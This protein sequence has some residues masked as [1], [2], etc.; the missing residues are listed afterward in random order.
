MR[1]KNL[2]NNKIAIFV[3][4]IK[5]EKKNNFQLNHIICPK[6][7]DFK[8]LALI[9]I[10]NEIIIKNCINK[11]KTIFYSLKDF[12]NS[13]Q[14][15]IKCKKCQMNIN[16]LNN[17]LYFNS[18]KEYICSLCKCNYKDSFKYIDNFYKCNKHNKAFISYCKE[19][20]FNLCNDCEIMHK[21]H[22][23]IYFKQLNI[24]EKK[25]N[26]IKENIEEFQNY[27]KEYKI[28]IKYLDL[29]FKDVFKEVL[30]NIKKEEI[31][32]EY[33]I[34][35][36]YNLKNYESLKNISNIDIKNFIKDIK[37]FLNEENIIEKMKYLYYKYEKIPKN[38]VIIKY[39]NDRTKIKIFGEEF[40][41]NNN[42]NC[43]MIFE[44]KKYKIQSFF[45]IK[46][47]NKI[48]E[49]K[50]IETKIIN[51]M[52]YM[53]SRCN[54][55]LSSS[56]ISKWD[57]SNV[58]NM[59]HI[60]GGCAELQFIPDISKWDTSNVTNMSEMFEYC[61][62]LQSLPDI[63]K[64]NTSNVT[65][66]NNLFR[67]CINLSSLPDISKWNTGN[68]TNM[69]C[70]FDDCRSLLT[71]PD[72]SNWDTS[73]V[74]NMSHMFAECNKLKSLPDISN[75]NTSNVTQMFRMF[76][77]CESLT[78]LPDISKWNILKADMYQMFVN[79]KKSLNIPKNWNIKNSI[80]D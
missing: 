30:N 15:D 27:I 4:K 23:I 5:S 25:R 51:D 61:C 53:F 17:D 60:F 45:P 20:N 16:N 1:I 79:C 72:I 22:E 11:H 13:Q 66:M 58:T 46:T 68:V 74:M 37:L 12:I 44:D 48:I 70:M 57:T 80:S 36:L 18:D 67:G 43:Y 76:Y 26:Q 54:S 56:D 7:Q 42:N 14:I 29:L 32:F 10:E 6:C 40:V 24:N 39:N 73:N 34:Y 52:S 3:S 33:I 63:S 49:I 55:L 19:C 2:V 28:Q 38:E 62:P 69:W 65:D 71:L 21:K 75:W 50:L 8:N 9:N 77:Y 78:S 47:K 31:L 41:K 35:S 59:S 64:W